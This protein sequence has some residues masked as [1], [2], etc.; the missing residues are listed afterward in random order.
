MTN[1]RI[2]CVV[3]KEN[4][5]PAEV[6][7]YLNPE[8]RDWLVKELLQ[9][10]ERRDHLHLLP[11]PEAETFPL[12]TEAYVPEDETAVWAVKMMFRPDAWDEQYFPHV[13]KG[14]AGS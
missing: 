3:T 6:L 10:N 13:M 1:P 5:E 4:G 9:L 14:D 7:F 12:R 11:G 2:T 8:G